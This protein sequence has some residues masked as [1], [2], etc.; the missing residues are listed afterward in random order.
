[1]SSRKSRVLIVDDDR[2]FCEVLVNILDYAGYLSDVAN[3][4]RT[5]LSKIEKNSFDLL[6]LD[7]KLPDMTGMRILKRAMKRK[8]PLQVVM[9]SGQGTIST[10]VEAVRIGAYDFLEK[11]L[12]SERVLVT[13][14]NALER[15]RL[16]REKAHLLESVR[17]HYA[18][19]GESAPMKKVRELIIKAAQANSKVLIEGKHGTGKELVV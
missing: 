11:P 8:P 4:G 12:D 10:A 13:V 5:A 18:M 15:G 6:V 9:I 3:D 17:E 14:K 16:E 1:M 19:V 2:S 7:L